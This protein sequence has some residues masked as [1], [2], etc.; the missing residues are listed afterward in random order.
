VF[1][2]SAQPR[3]IHSFFRVDRPERAARFDNLSPII[4]QPAVARQNFLTRWAYIYHGGAH[5]WVPLSR[6][7]PS[8]GRPSFPFNKSLQFFTLLHKKGPL[9]CSCAFEGSKSPLE[10]ESE[11]GA[12]LPTDRRK[13][14]FDF[15][16]QTRVK[17]VPVYYGSAPRSAWQRL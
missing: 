2:S 13:G 17:L 5:G 6:P 15:S 7:V 14:R 1:C 11:S 8:W 3:R 10:R 9:A 12:P 16:R 4:T